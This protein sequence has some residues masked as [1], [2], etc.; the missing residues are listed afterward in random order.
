[1]EFLQQKSIERKSGIVNHIFH[2]ALDERVT[3]GFCPQQVRDWYLKEQGGG[4][5]SV[6]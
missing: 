2:L 3:C 6:V 4:V 5:A 1:L